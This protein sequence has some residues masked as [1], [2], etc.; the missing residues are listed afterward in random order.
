MLWE[1]HVSGRT[2]TRSIETE[3]EPEAIAEIVAD[4]RRI[5]E[6]APAFA[7]RVE[8]D[9]SN[10]WRV[11]KDGSDFALEVVV[12]NAGRTIRYLREVAPGRKSGADIRV[13]ARPAG[14]SVVVFT[15]PVPPDR[16]AADV[17]VV[18]RR[19][20]DSLIQLSLAS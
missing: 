19:E 16:T 1:L 4:A 3:A 9:G 13:M 14:G 10:A 7:D 18:L 15:L 8:A 2:V 5:P 6:W 20:M 11:T 12:G 17:N